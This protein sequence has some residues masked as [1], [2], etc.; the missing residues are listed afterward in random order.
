M[1]FSASSIIAGLLFGFFGM[2]LFKEGK[3]RTSVELYFVALAMMIYP[4]FITDA[5][6]V[7]VIGIALTA[8]AIQMLK[9]G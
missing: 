8:A 4:Y 3:K 9:K 1:N 2:L 7:W 5:I 6:L